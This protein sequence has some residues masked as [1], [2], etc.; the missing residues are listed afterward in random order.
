MSEVISKINELM[1]AIRQQVSNQDSSARARSEKLDLRGT[2]L[3]TKDKELG[4]RE[5]KVKYIENV[6]ILRNQA[7]ADKE[8]TDIALK[9]LKEEKAAWGIKYE[10][11]KK[12]LNEVS[13]KATLDSGKSKNELVMIQKEWLGL[14]KEQETWKEKFMESLKKKLK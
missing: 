7:L 3:A 10:A 6:A 5:A 2:E 11:E 12:A 9:A 8:T 1:Q 13:K 4:D 14:K